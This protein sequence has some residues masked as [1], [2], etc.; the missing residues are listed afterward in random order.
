VQAVE[1]LRFLLLSHEPKDIVVA[2]DSA[3]GNLAFAV[4]AHLATPSPYCPPISLQEG[5]R[6]RALLLLAP[7][8]NLVRSTESYKRNVQYDCIPE[9]DGYM[10]LANWAPVLNDSFADALNFPPERLP[11]L[12]VQDVLLT[13]GS[14]EVLC[15]DLVLLGSRFGVELDHKEVLAGVTTMGTANSPSQKNEV[16]FKILVAGSE[17]HIVPLFESLLG[18]DEGIMAKV[19]REWF[20]ELGASL[21]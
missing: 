4:V 11:T 3:G 12:P 10:F 5:A 18:L 15:D 14:H 2:G 17:V 7:W 9:S 13:A 20:Q 21:H 1:A 8:V 6:L 16:N 19:I